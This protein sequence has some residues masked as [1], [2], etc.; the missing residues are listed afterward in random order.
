MRGAADRQAPPRGT[1]PRHELVPRSRVRVPVRW[2][3]GGCQWVSAP[4]RRG[5][6]G[7]RDPEHHERVCVTAC[8]GVCVHAL[9]HETTPSTQHRLLPS[10][11]A[12]APT[13]RRNT[14]RPFNHWHVQF[15]RTAVPKRSKMTPATKT[16][17]NNAVA[18]ARGA[19]SA[20]EL[21]RWRP[22]AGALKEHHGL[23]PPTTSTIRPT[24]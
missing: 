22:V 20:S 5:G 18:A 14:V 6:A 16:S 8:G 1:L 12:R 3:V 19:D 23:G 13:T 24:E 2:R 17:S 10:V 15:F 21:Q 11:C 4:R 7:S 9:P